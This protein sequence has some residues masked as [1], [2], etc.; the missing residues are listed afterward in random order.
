MR[1]F[2][3]L[4]LLIAAVVPVAWLSGQSPA[5]SPPTPPQ[6]NSPGLSLIPPNS[7]PFPGQAVAPA[8]NSPPVPGLITGPAIGYFPVAST[9]TQQAVAVYADPHEQAAR[10]LAERYRSTQDPKDKTAARAELVELTKR[11]FTE[12]TEARRKQIAA[13]RAELDRIEA[14]LDQRQ[15][16]EKE[17]VDRRVAQLL[18]EPDVL[19]W[20]SPLDSTGPNLTGSSLGNGRIIQRFYDQPASFG[21]GPAP[22]PGSFPAREP[23]YL[24][25]VDGYPEPTGRLGPPHVPAA[26]APPQ[27]SPNTSPSVQRPPRAQEPTPDSGTLPPAAEE[28]FEP[29]EEREK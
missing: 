4:S 26:S 2:F 18:D 20:N 9:I 6:Q 19:D 12:R 10:Q 25:Y 24:N 3:L 14:H 8:P 16:L 13:A 29:A 17:I 5:T 28:K 21:S 7:L 1:R 23:S 27:P 22:T 15:K 11:A